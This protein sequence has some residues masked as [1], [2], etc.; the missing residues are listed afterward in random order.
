MC[1]FLLYFLVQWMI[2]SSIRP[3]SPSGNLNVTLDSSL[4]F[5]LHWINY[6]ILLSFTPN[7]SWISLFP[8]PRNQPSSHHRGPLT[9]SP[10]HFRFPSSRRVSTPHSLHFSLMVSS[11]WRPWPLSTP[12]PPGP[13]PNCFSQQLRQWLGKLLESWLSSPSYPQYLV[14][15]LALCQRTMFFWKEGKNGFGSYR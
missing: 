15:F 6:Q 10:R 5:S 1:C 7:I 8:F 2:P 3:V 9:R 12:L 4:P 14:P 13:C 11:A